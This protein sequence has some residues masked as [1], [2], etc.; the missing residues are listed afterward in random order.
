MEGWLVAGVACGGAAFGAAGWTA[1]AASG[2][3][4][5]DAINAPAP[6]LR[7]R[8]SKWLAGETCGFAS[9]EGGRGQA[10]ARVGIIYSIF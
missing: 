10:R 5:I 3:R 2:I 8:T 6:A 9:Y 1:Q 7:M 4:N